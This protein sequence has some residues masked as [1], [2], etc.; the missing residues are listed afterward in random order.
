VSDHALHFLLDRLDFDAQKR[1]VPGSRVMTDY[2]KK[3]VVE[4]QEILKS[5]SLPYSGKKADLVA[6]LNE[7]DKVAEASGTCHQSFATKAVSEPVEL[8]RC[9]GHPHPLPTISLTRALSVSAKA[10]PAEATSAAP[11]QTTEATTQPSTETP[12]PAVPA[13]STAASRPA[14][15]AEEPTTGAS[16]S[17]NTDAALATRTSYALNLPSSD[18]DSEL[19]KRKA[20]A[21][22]FGIANGTADPPGT[23]AADI[24]AQKTLE[25]AKRFGTGQT[26]V[27]KLD[28]ALPSE[29]ER[30]PRKRGRG[31]DADE[32]SALDDPGLR[33]NFRGKFKPGAPRRDNSRRRAGEKP[34]GVVKP[35]GVFSSEA[36]RLAA[37]ARKK[38][39]GNVS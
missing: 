3:T 34:T 16:P 35:S 1:R 19:A 5:R 7:S 23:E 9:G 29:V 36:D 8:R 21:E 25:R 11:E 22:R 13:P 26:A 12:A 4:L 33:K 28:E 30:G 37:E 32:P 10:S 20:R 39:W 14:P 18:I 15:S 6:R 17:T 27:G 31:T 24:E 2:A 38:K